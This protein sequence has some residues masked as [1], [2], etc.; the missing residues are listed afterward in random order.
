MA[1][2]QWTSSKQLVQND[3]KVFFTTI[4]NGSFLTKIYSKKI[5]N[6]SDVCYE[7]KNVISLEEVDSLYATIRCW[8]YSLGAT[9]EVGLQ[10]FNN[11]LSFWDFHVKH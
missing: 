3:Y 6:S 2:S 11:W 10:E 5:R 1:Q 4:Q 7:Y 9:N 8:W